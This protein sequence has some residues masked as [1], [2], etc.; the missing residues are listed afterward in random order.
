M[1][2]AFTMIELVIAIVII[3]ILSTIAIQKLH[4]NTLTSAAKSVINDLRYLQYLALNNDAYDGSKTYA[5]KRWQFKKHCVANKTFGGRQ[6][7]GT[8][9]GYTIFSDEDGDGKIKPD[10]SELTTD[11]LESDKFLG[12]IYENTTLKIDKF[13][14]R[15][16]LTKAF[17]INNIR[18]FYLHQTPTG[19]NIEEDDKFFLNELGETRINNLKSTII[20]RLQKNSA[21]TTTASDSI[22]IKI[23]GKTGFIS[24]SEWSSSKQNVTINS[25]DIECHKIKK[26]SI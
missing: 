15:T 8:N 21:N 12:A 14:A 3:G 22:C 17:G 23:E 5:S 1:K 7:C 20:M 13:P 11:Y 9:I 24:V 18:I 6:I 2:K 25:K 4:T 16:D 10:G 19:A 26:G